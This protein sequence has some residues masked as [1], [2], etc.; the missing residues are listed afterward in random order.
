MT[1]ELISHAPA[2]QVAWRRGL[3]GEK[4]AYCGLEEGIINEMKDLHKIHPYK[5][6]KG[7]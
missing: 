2:G 7:A 6:K 1:E 4:M 5:E 3:Y